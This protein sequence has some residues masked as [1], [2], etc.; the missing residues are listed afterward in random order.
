M[1][2]HAFCRIAGAARPRR[3]L[4]PQALL[5]W[6]AGGGVVAAIAGALQQMASQLHLG[7]SAGGC[8]AVTPEAGMDFG[9]NQV[10]LLQEDQHQQQGNPQQQQRGIRNKQQQPEWLGSTGSGSS[11]ERTPGAPVVRELRITNVHASRSVLL[12]NVCV[13]SAGWLLGGH[14]EAQY[15]CLLPMEHK[16]GVYPLRCALMLS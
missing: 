5:A 3:A 4:L 16:S 7:A 1:H 12:L 8:I 13:V 9:T 15:C 2:V 14:L 6:A 11:S 10:L